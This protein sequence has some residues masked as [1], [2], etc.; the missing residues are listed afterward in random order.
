MSQSADRAALADRAAPAAA[1]SKDSARARRRSFAIT[2]AVVVILLIVIA[3]ALLGKLAISRYE[4]YLSGLWVGD[5]SFLA[6][7]QLRDMQLFLAPRED[8]RR[9]GYLIMTDASGNF[10]SNQAIEVQVRSAPQRW[11]TA[12]KSVFRSASDAYKASEVEVEYD[13]CSSAGDGGPSA[14][15]G[16]PSAD[17]AEPPMPTHMKMSLSVLDGTLT[18]YDSEKVYAFL[19]KDLVASAAAVEAY[20]S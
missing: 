13:A 4:N 2:I 17:G 15:D 16:G 18:F 7:A 5:P 1:P 8:G 10:I 19:E 14:G 11:W 12:L 9:Q 6:Q 20:K 3:A